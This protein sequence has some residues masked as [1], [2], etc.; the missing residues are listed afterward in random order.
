MIVHQNTKHQTKE[1]QLTSQ[2]LKK[3]TTRK[4]VLDPQG[5]RKEESRVVQMMITMSHNLK[6]IARD[7]MQETKIPINATLVEKKEIC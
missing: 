1:N 3:Q 7:S 2:Q 6:V 5:E 4:R